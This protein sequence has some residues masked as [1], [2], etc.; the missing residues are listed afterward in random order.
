LLQSLTKDLQLAAQAARQLFAEA[1]LVLLP[2]ECGDLPL[3]LGVVVRA[4]H[5]RADRAPR[6]EKPQKHPGQPAEA[7]RLGLES[8]GWFGRPLHL[9]IDDGA[10]SLGQRIVG[11]AVLRVEPSEHALDTLIPLGSRFGERTRAH[12]VLKALVG[13]HREEIAELQTGAEDPEA[14]IGDAQNAERRDAYPVRR[15][16]HPHRPGVERCRDVVEEPWL[17]GHRIR[18]L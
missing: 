3:Q 4:S 17:G 7:V 12:G 1:V 14:G 11:A 8:V 10:A 13:R 2:F 5:Y 6:K 18:S 9:Q 16:E 15:H